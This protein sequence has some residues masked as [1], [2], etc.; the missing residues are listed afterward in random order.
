MQLLRFSIEHSA[1]E[2]DIPR[3]DQEED[4]LLRRMDDIIDFWKRHGTLLD[5]HAV[6]R[7]LKSHHR[8]GILDPLQW[9]M[10]KLLC[11][12]FFEGRGDC[13]T[14]GDAKIIWDSKTGM[15]QSTLQSRCDIVLVSQNLAGKVGLTTNEPCFHLPPDSQ[16]YVDVVSWLRGI[17]YSCKMGEVKKVNEH[18]L[19]SR[20]AIEGCE[21][22]NAV[23]HQRF[24]PCVQQVKREIVVVDGY[25]QPDSLIDLLERIDNDA[26]EGCQVIIYSSV[27]RGPGLDFCNDLKPLELNKI[28]KVAI[29]LVLQYHLDRTGGRDRFI[30]YDDHAHNFLHGAGD[31]FGRNRV[32]PSGGMYDV[33]DENHVRRVERKMRRAIDSSFTVCWRHCSKDEPGGVHCK[34]PHS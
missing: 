23:W 15:V 14:D 19:E 34:C 3:T 16:S 26:S 22:V 27:Q 7:V 21:L 33:V 32:N 31:M 2:Q 13:R 12:P 11:K 17:H 24:R 18:A 28:T 4:F 8:Q 25:A 9:D 1:I 30:R 5:P 29:N 6:Y 10:I 20:T